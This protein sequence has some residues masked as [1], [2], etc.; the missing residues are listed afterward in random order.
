MKKVLVVIVVLVS[1]FLGAEKGSASLLDSNC[2][3]L[4]KSKIA[5]KI[6]GGYNAGMF[7]NPWMVRVMVMGKQTCGGSLITSRNYFIKIIEFI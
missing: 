4:K 3:I 6:A 7:S 5:G 2:V 1:P